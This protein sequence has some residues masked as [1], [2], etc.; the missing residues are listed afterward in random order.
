MTIDSSLTTRSL[1]KNLGIQEILNYQGITEVA[2][3][4]GLEIWFDRGNGWEV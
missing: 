3:N 1:L 2:I 4:Q